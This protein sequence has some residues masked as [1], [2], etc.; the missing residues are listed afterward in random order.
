MT[1]VSDAPT[2][3]RVDAPS[4]TLGTQLVRIITT[5]DLHVVAG[6]WHEHDDGDHDQRG[7][8]HHDLQ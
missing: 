7:R 5:T 3:A 1:A 6:G 2:G 4:P 8:G